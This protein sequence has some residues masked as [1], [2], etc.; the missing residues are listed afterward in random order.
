M[1]RNKQI[2]G[3]ELNMDSVQKPL[4]QTELQ[5]GVVQSYGKDFCAQA[6][7]VLHLTGPVQL[8]VRVHICLSVFWGV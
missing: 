6:V 1:N 4:K 3:L 8:V 5:V 7:C 2:K